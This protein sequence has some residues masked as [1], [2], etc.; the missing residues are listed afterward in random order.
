MS[1]PK[2]QKRISTKKIEQ[3]SKINTV[4]NITNKADY[5][6][7]FLSP[8]E[9]LKNYKMMSHIGKGCFSTVSL[10]IH[11]ETNQNYALK[12]YEKIDNLEW[13]RLE[14]IKK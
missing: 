13:Y 5:F 7:E 9:L 3:N 11:K 10:A 4:K 8:Y 2:T 1:L 6:D 12:T 14:G